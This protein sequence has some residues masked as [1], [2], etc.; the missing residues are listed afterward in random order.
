M[1]LL[2]T[3]APARGWVPRGLFSFFSFPVPCSWSFS[4]SHE[5]SLITSLP[6]LCWYLLRLLINTS[7][8][9]KSYFL[10]ACLAT[11]TSSLK[12]PKLWCIFFCFS[13]IF[14]P[15][16]STVVL[17]FF[18]L[19]HNSWAYSISLKWLVGKCIHNLPVCIINWGVFFQYFCLKDLIK[20]VLELRIWVRCGQPQLFPLKKWQCLA[21]SRQVD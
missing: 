10:C 20:P 3:G 18:C 5:V 4:L 16:L 14:F 8:S 15:L 19:P 7:L 17:G 6:G 21:V 2:Y 9:S 11:L 12:I 1:I 13:C